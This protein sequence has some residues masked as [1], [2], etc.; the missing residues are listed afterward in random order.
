M[1]SY[2][3][4]LV[5]G[6]IAGNREDLSKLLE[7]CMKN[8]LYMTQLYSNR[9]DA[10]DIAQEV[11]ITLQRKIHTLSDPDRFAQ[12]LSVI[13][14]NASFNYMRKNHKLKNN[15]ELETYMERDEFFDKFSVDKVEFLPEQ[16]VEDAEL[17]K[18]V[19]EEISKLPKNQKICLAYHYLQEFKRAD[20]AEA[21]GFTPEQVTTAL[22]GGKKTLKKRLEE[23]LGNTL[24]FSMA[25]VSAIPAMAR[26]F[27]A[28]QEEMVPMEWCEQ[29]L[30]ASLE[31][32]AGMGCAGATGMSTVTKCLIGAAVCC[33]AVVVGVASYNLLSGD[34]T[35]AETVSPP[36][37]ST[38]QNQED[39]SP[40][41]TQDEELDEPTQEEREIR[42]VADMIGEEEADILEGFLDHVDNLEEWR[43][44]LERIDTREYGRASEYQNTYITY[45][46]EKQNKRL[47]LA[48]HD[49]G[50]GTI[51]VIY[52]FG[53][54]EEPV[55]GIARIILRF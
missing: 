29:V 23:R 31:S 7:C 32:I 55:E 42:T 8:V 41:F 18:I 34:E 28:M 25:P 12:W 52:L 51:Q 15:V 10:E 38:M 24:V 2:P 54:R 43:A 40:T 21:T 20:I 48:E 53:D 44:F 22:Y 17:C 6:A 47:L 49:P 11:A 33:T 14:R 27:Q 1:K 26:A 35:P 13:V 30:Q 45:I 16:Y 46:L 37:I 4:P 5:E 36:A 19:T 3:N 50:D 39:M 9:Q